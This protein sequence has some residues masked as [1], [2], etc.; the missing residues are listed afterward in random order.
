[1]QRPRERL[2]PCGGAGSSSSNGW[3]P[4]AHG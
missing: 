4:T 2:Q 3:T 1:L